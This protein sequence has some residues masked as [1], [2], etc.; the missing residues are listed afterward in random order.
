MGLGLASAVIEGVR[1][2]DRRLTWRMPATAREVYL[3]FDDGPMPGLT[4]FALGTLA[5]YGAKATFFCIGAHIAEHP[6]LFRKLLEAG[7]AI[8]NHTH[9]HENGW[10]TPKADYLRSVAECQEL[11]RTDLFRPPYGR[12]TNAQI[13]GVRAS[14][15]Q[16]VMWD[17]LSGDF[18]E[19]HTGEHVAASV[20]R[21]TRP[22]SIIVFHDNAISEARMRVALPIVLEGLSK[23]GYGFPVLPTRPLALT[24]P[25]CP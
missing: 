3:T 9:R 24:G 25:R 21:R 12:I 14:G 1:R 6:A 23:Q 18:E 17:V 19:K 11:T 5:R 20:L 2:L 16:V 10:R 15:L 4:E 7:H 22:G 13:K 8:G